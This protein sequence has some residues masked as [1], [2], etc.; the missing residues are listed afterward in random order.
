MSNPLKDIFH[1]VR[2]SYNETI[3]AQFPF[4]CLMGFDENLRL[5]FPEQLTHLVVA[6]LGNE[7]NY[8]R[9]Y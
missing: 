4:I 1:S 2:V 3:L 9:S 7:N 8:E 5:D 6:Q